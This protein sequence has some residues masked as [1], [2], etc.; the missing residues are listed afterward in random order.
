MAAFVMQALGC[1]VASLNTVHYSNHTGYGQWTGTKTSGEDVRSLYNGLKQSSLTDFDMMLTGYAPSAAVVE[2]VGYIARDLK[3]MNTTKPGSFFWVLDSVMGDQGKLYVSPEVVPAYKQILRDADLILPNQFELQTLSSIEI[4]SRSS[5]ESAIAHLHSTYLIP[6]ILVTSVSLPKSTQN[7]LSSSSYSSTN[8]TDSTSPTTLFIIGSTYSP[9]THAPRIFS[10]EIPYLPAFFSGTGDMLAALLVVRLR[11]AVLA[12]GLDRTKSWVSPEDVQAVDL[13]LAKAAERVLGC[14]HIVL[15]KTMESARRDSVVERK[16]GE[17]GGFAG[18]DDDDANVG[19]GIGNTDD[20]KME[21]S[22]VK[23]GDED[24]S[25]VKAA[26][27]AKHLR[28]TKALEIKLV[29]N[30]ADLR[31][32]AVR[33]WAKEFKI[34]TDDANADEADQKPTGADDEA[35]MAMEGDEVEGKSC[36]DEITEPKSGKKESVEKA[37]E[38]VD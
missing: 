24:E 14:M 28:E 8:D 11:E 20:E 3:L 23:E 16:E 5:L 27:K 7:P 36:E 21:G 30:I 32:G 1:D 34:N 17:G 4:D 22:A 10:I 2:A 35:G 37:D 38:S 13:P 33:Y 25:K 31:E 15:E 18:V 19:A 29:R 6:H 26:S 9:Q 12:A